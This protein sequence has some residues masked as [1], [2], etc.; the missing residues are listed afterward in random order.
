LTGIDPA[1]SQKLV[2]N[3]YDMA[4]WTVESQQAGGAVLAT[5]PLAV[6]EWD[7]QSFIQ[8]NGTDSISPGFVRNIAGTFTNHNP[9]TMMLDQV[10]PWGMACRF[11]LPSDSGS[12]LLFGASDPTST[13]V[14]P[15][16]V[17]CGFEHG[18]NSR[19]FQGY[20]TNTG[21][22]VGVDNLASTVQLDAEWHTGYVFADASGSYKFSVDGEAPIAL[23]NVN[24]FSNLL[25]CPRICFA[26]TT[27]RVSWCSAVWLG[28]P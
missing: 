21:A 22:G 16:G 14:G 27:P 15:K 12:Y 26:S 2:K 3:F 5:A 10:M 8:G 25:A 17:Y 9:R 1:R 4:G 23:P 20:K 11:Q 19:F 6:A 7:G 28:S 13:G 18:T 24:T